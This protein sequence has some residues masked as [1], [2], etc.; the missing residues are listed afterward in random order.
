MIQ[1]WFVENWLQAATFL[2]VAVMFFKVSR[3]SGIVDTR[4]ANLEGWMKGHMERH[5]GGD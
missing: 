3:W 2:A 1:Q 4:V 5:H